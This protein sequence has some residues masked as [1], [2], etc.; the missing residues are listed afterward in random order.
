MY[1]IIE[2][3]NFRQNLKVKNSEELFFTKKGAS[4]I[5]NAKYIITWSYD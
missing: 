3:K 4:I 5:K 1:Y 2:I